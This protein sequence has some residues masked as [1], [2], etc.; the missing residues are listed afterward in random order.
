MHKAVR[1]ISLDK[2]IKQ[3]AWQKVFCTRKWERNRADGLHQTITL[4]AQQGL[5]CTSSLNRAHLKKQLLESCKIT[6]AGRQS[7]AAS[8]RVLPHR[9]EPAIPICLRPTSF[10][11]LCNMD[12]KMRSQGQL[13]LTKQSAQRSSHIASLCSPCAL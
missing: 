1:C 11:P 5:L 13:P 3:Y 4:S 7:L 6:M 8:P 10:P 9:P 12:A 2:T